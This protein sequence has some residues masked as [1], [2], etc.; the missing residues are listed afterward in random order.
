MY[1]TVVRGAA[2]Y[3]WQPLT[4]YSLTRVSALGEGTLSGPVA[5][6]TP[7]A[8]LIP[9]T[10]RQTNEWHMSEGRG[11]LLTTGVNEH[12]TM[13]TDTHMTGVTFFL[14][15]WAPPPLLLTKHAVPL[16]RSKIKPWLERIFL[17]RAMPQIPASARSQL[18]FTKTLFLPH[19]IP[20]S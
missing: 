12:G 7:Y 11:S 6:A 1:G 19:C 16:R 13:D 18:S 9:F 20:Q 10:F 2:C 15:C 17:P 4:A 8:R 3:P 14:H 5:R